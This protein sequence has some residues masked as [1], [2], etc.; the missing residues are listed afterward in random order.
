MRAVA[1]LL[2][3]PSRIPFSL[4]QSRAPFRNTSENQVPVQGGAVDDRGGLDDRGV[5]VPGRGRRADTARH[6]TLHTRDVSAEVR[7]ERVLRL[8]LLRIGPLCAGLVTYLTHIR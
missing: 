5:R 2:P 3:F 8:S 4:T 7:E 1:E 6:H